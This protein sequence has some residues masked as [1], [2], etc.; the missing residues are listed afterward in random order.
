MRG[1]TSSAWSVCSRC[2]AVTAD[3]DR[4]DQDHNDTD[5]RL[6]ELEA[7]L[8]ALSAPSDSADDGGLT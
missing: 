2:G 1:R 4:H 6:A 3:P 8:G 7:A 5:A